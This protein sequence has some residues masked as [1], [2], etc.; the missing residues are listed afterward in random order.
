M[1]WDD[2]DWLLGRRYETAFR[3][4][5][6][7]EKEADGDRTATLHLH[8]DTYELALS[9]LRALVESGLVFETPARAPWEK[10]EKK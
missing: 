3:V 6:L 7:G 4:V 5:G 10:E 9:E 1:N 8:G 2:P